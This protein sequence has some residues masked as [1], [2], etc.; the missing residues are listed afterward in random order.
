MM[1][2]GPALAHN[3]AMN[4][5]I[6]GLNEQETQL[7]RLMYS[8]AVRKPDGANRLEYLFESFMDAWEAKVEDERK[9]KNC[10]LKLVH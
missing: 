9:E 4:N 6:N 10:H 8:V 1:R 2:I 5:L 3:G 7:M